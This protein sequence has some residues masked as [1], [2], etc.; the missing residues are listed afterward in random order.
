M[1]TITKRFEFSA[2][3]QL[4]HLDPSHKCATLHG[5]NY[6]VEIELQALA[7]DEQGFVLDYGCL[8]PFKDYIDRELDHQNLNKVLGS[9]IATT[10]ENLAL[11]LYHKA[12]EYYGQ[13]TAV[14]VSE[15]PKT[16]AEYRP[17]VIPTGLPNGL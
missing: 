3:H 14:R 10:A 5:H 1:F 9:G 15:T 13:V 4:D 2:A 7:L 12:R 17:P 11:G 16:W 8:A 6:I